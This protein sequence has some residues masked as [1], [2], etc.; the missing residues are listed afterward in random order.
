MQI[1]GVGI[2]L[3]DIRRIERVYQIYGQRFL[4]KIFTAIEIELIKNTKDVSHRIS[5]TCD[6]IK[7]SHIILDYDPEIL[8][9]DDFIAIKIGN[10]ISNRIENYL[11]RI[12]SIAE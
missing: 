12:V 2:D 6:I 11:N 3:V 5:K 7:F 4:E 9:D 1:I 8:T 10:N